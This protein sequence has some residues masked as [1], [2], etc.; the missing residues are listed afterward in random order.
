[1]QHEAISFTLDGADVAVAVDPDTALLHVLRNDL[2]ART[3]RFG[4]GEG[5]CGACTVLVDGRALASCDTPLWSVAGRQVRTVASV[6]A[7]PRLRVLL[8]TIEEGQAA[9]CGYCLPGIVMTALDLLGRVDRP[10]RATI[11]EA[12]DGHLCRC[13]AHLRILK[14]VEEAGRRLAEKEERA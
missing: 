5:S 6:E 12:L 11:A 9:Q 7:D 2:G 13:G 14:A 4:C 3:P 1:M 10:S 8:E